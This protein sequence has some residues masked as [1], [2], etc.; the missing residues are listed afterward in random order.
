[1]CR[2]SIKNSVLTNTSSCSACFSPICFLKYKCH[3][4]CYVKSAHLRGHLL[5]STATGVHGAM[6]I[7]AHMSL[8]R[9]VAFHKQDPWKS[10]Q[11]VIAACFT[12]DW[13]LLRGTCMPRSMSQ[14]ESVCLGYM[15]TPVRKQP[16]PH[17]F[18][19]SLCLPQGSLVP[20][21]PIEAC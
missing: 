4:T 13:R 17:I 18:S 1:M 19:C 5:L 10:G 9:P 7:F 3:V 16:S 20:L 11:W 6:G 12:P 15:P 2:D 8:C 14:V 21:S